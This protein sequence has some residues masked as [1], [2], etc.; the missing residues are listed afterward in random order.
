M[1]D[2]GFYGIYQ[3][4]LINSNSES[5]FRKDVDKEH[6]GYSKGYHI[7]KKQVEAL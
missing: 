7:D 6:H 4:V 5:F 2:I 1:E 3:I